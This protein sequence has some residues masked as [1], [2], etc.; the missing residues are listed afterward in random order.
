MME[1]VESKMM[2]FYETSSIANHP[3]DFQELST[4]YHG[5][6]HEQTQIQ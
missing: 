5:L 3:Q 1:V 2:Y 4:E 6:V